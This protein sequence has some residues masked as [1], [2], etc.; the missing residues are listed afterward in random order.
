MFEEMKALVKNDTCDMISRLFD[1]NTV[2]ASRYTQE[3]ISSKEK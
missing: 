3:S 2:N 1:K